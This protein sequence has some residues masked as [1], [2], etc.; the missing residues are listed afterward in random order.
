MGTCCSCH[1]APRWGDSFTTRGVREASM[2]AKVHRAL[3]KVLKCLAPKPS[4][5]TQR[6]AL[7]EKTLDFI[8]LSCPPAVHTQAL[9]PSVYLHP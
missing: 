5:L 4:R 8:H 7:A 6:P 2:R 1:N 3:S 9:V